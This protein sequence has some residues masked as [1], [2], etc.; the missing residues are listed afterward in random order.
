[1]KDAQ[2]NKVQLIEEL[3]QARC[4]IA[5]LM[6]DQVERKRVEEALR[7]SEAKFAMVFHATPNL[8]AITRAED[9]LIVDVN[10]AFASKLGYGRDELLGRR[11][12]ELGLWESLEKRIEVAG[13]IG[14][15]GQAY[16][17]EVETRTKE[18]EKFLLLFSGGE[19]DIGGERH[20]VTLASD[21][22]E[23]KQAEEEVQKLA[24]AVKHSGELV[25]LA[26]LEGNMVFLNEA[27]SRILGIDP[28]DIEHVNIMEVIP[29]QWVDLVESD[30]LPTLRRGDIWEGDLQYTNLK[31]GKLTDVH[32]MTFTVKDP[33][34]QEP[35]FLANVSMDIT[36]RKRAEEEKLMLERQVQ[37]AQKLES[38]GVLA[39]GI[40]HD[41]NNLLVGIMGN[42]DL[43]LMDL[44]PEAPARE[45]ILDIET[46]AKRASDL[47]KQ[48][49]AY[50]GKGKFVVQRIDLQTLVEEMVHLLEVSISKKVVIRYDFAENV[51]SIEA[52]ATQV[53][54][55]IMNL[56][57][58]A[59]ETI[60]NKSGVITIRTG[61]MECDRTYLDDTYFDNELAEGA[62][63]YFEISDTGSGIDEETITKIFDPFFSTKFTGRGLGLAAVLGIVRGHSGAIKVYSEPGKGTTFKVLFPIA[64][65]RPS[66][67]KSPEIREFDSK[68]MEGKSVLLVDDEETVRTVGRMMLEVLGLDVT[69]AEDGRE[70][71]E[72]VKQDPDR[73]DCVI[74]DLTMPHM[75]GEETF[76]EMRRIRKD[77]RVLLSSGY[78]EQDLIARFASKGFAG[79]IQ[80]PYMTS[81]IE[82]ALFKAFNFKT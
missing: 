68:K 1:M 16:G 18:G 44:A 38:L 50:S 36:E 39:G 76:R 51:P 72:L 12:V 24:A 63:S 54:Q 33:D 34:T 19:V 74:L 82:E 75:D 59:S 66:V 57:V 67:S 20:F 81:D 79:F 32:A 37:Q 14:E 80:K 13:V 21:I 31:T 22:T 58:N 45:R 11:T 29:E 2:K 40:A 62:Y 48:M 7:E 65:S 49:L 47:T 43:A 64:E 71:L 35:L 42:A 3:Q 26:T 69:T 15:H 55:I 52:D 9:G 78:N 27:G 5:E 8:M 61:A 4:L 46:A 73:F 70:A 23:R 56:V 77:I 30:L 25:N 10:D 53:R 28:Q 60:G 17:L 41:F 6:G